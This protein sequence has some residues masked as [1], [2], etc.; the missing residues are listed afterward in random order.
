MCRM[1]QQGFLR[2][3]TNPKAMNI[4]LTHAQAWKACERFLTEDR[5]EYA[6]EPP[7]IASQWKAYPKN[8]KFSPKIWNDA[9]LA[10]F[11]KKSAMTMLTFDKGFT[12]YKGLEAHILS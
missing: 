4:P 9:Y 8:A 5:I 2:L 7:E 12:A 1:T 10:A 6:E 3:S 11:A